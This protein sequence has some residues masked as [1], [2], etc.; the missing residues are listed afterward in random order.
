MIKFFIIKKLN[1]KIKK[2]QSKLADLYEDSNLI[3][4]EIYNLNYMPNHESLIYKYMTNDYIEKLK[5][6]MGR[7]YISQSYADMFSDLKYINVIPYL[8]QYM[9]TFKDFVFEYEYGVIDNYK[10]TKLNG[11]EFICDAN[12]VVQPIVGTVITWKN[13]TRELFAKIEPISK[14]HKGKYTWFWHTNCLNSKEYFENWI[15]NLDNK[16]NQI[17]DEIEVL[18]NE[19]NALQ[20]SR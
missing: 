20:G 18:I 10:I 19:R 3:A 1:R 13:G 11:E 9:E 2:L 6:K 7:F 4:K 17:N 14:N 15:N 8:Q 12:D 16:I 5:E